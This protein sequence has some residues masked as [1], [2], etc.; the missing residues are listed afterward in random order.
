MKKADLIK[1]L[2]ENEI[3]I[4]GKETVKDLEAIAK[5]NEI[6]ITEEPEKE[7]RMYFTLKGKESVIDIK[8]SEVEAHVKAGWRLEK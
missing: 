4:T 1:L 2:E 8:E 3:E 6:E 5:E 7:V